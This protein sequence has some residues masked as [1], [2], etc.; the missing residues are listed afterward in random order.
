MVGAGIVVARSVARPPGVH[1]VDV[2][3]TP[4]PALLTGVPAF[5]GPVVANPGPP[6]RVA[7]W[8][9]FTAEFGT[10]LPGFVAAAVHGFFAN[11]GGYC[12]VVPLDE[13]EGI[14]GREAIYPL[15]DGMTSKRLG[16]LA[17]QAIERAP[18]PTAAALR[19]MLSWA[20]GR[21]ADEIAGAESAC[22]CSGPHGG[23]HGHP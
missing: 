19:H 7:L 14:G 16:M 15:S 2:F 17:G 18:D 4:E 22:A 10:D 11:D 13:A 20:L 1:P 21:D 23:G 5:L 8:P 3:P 12:H 6:R 9:Q